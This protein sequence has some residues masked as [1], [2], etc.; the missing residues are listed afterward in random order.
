LTPVRLPYPLLCTLIG[1][2]IGWLPMLFHGPIPYKFDIHYI[3]GSIAVWDWY[4]SRAM[5]GFFVGITVWPRL[6]W[7]RG[8]LMGVLLMLP[9]C[10]VSLA[11]PECGPPCM[12]WNEVTGTMIGFA[13]AGVAYAITR[14][15][16]AADAPS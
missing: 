1:L 14:R 12:F 15:H 13:V 5:I 7:M 8:P 6:W 11:T 3:R 16:H 4:L 10:M 9:P 2:A